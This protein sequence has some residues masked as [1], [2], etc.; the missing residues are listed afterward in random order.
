MYDTRD[1]G[2]GSVTFAESKLRRRGQARMANAVFKVPQHPLV[3][4]GA[5]SLQA[6]TKI[7]ES[8]FFLKMLFFKIAIPFRD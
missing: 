5:Q 2:G 3:R 7:G 1:S 6:A 8:I 4:V